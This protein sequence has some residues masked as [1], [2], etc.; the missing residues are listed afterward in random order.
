[1]D[2]NPWGA[3]DQLSTRKLVRSATPPCSDQEKAPAERSY[4]RLAGGF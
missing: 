1:V 2:A 3:P 4:E